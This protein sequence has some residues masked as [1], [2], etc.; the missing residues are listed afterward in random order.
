MGKKGRSFL[1]QFL[2]DGFINAIDRPIDLFIRLNIHPNFFTI[3]GLLIAILAAI[4]YAMGDIRLGGAFVLLAGMSDTFD[5]KIARKQGIASK[6]G[7]VFDSSLDRYAEFL[8]FFG[9]GA[10][11][12]QRGDQVSIITAIVAFIA[13]IG[14]VMVS[15]VRARAEGIGYECKVGVMQRAERIVFTGVSSL[16]HPIALMVVI[17]IIAILANVTAI[18]RMHYVWKTERAEL[19]KENSDETLGI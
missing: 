19:A 4:F 11:F 9:L 17:W 14:S 3:L 13:L 7:A 6:F 18:Q 15:Y 2:K 10:Y 8:M 16:I 12:L 1:P 5:G